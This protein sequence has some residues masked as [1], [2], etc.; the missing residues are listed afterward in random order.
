MII[1]CEECGEKYIIEPDEIKGTAL[2]FIC[3]VCND[4]I[5]VPTHEHPKGKQIKADKKKD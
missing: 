4:I 5:K 2:I 1:F 3:R